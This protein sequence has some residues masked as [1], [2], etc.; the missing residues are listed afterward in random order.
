M[1]EGL[2]TYENGTWKFLDF[3]GEVKEYDSVSIIFDKDEPFDT[4]LKHGKS[5]DMQ[6][7]YASGRY[8]P[9]EETGSF[10]IVCLVPPTCCEMLNKC[11]SISG[12]KWCS[13]ILI[14]AN[15]YY[16]ELK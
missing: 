12:S 7:L 4:L 5:R 6:A 14:E 11:I 2:Y 9:L 13:L 16:I 3:D 1:T 15:K 10:V 8:I